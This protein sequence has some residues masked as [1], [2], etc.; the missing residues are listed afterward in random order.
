M[1]LLSLDLNKHAPDPPTAGELRFQVGLLAA[2][3]ATIASFV[4][5]FVFDAPLVPELLAQF[6][7]AIAPIWMVEIA[8]GMLGPFAKHLAFLGC[9]AIYL[10]GLI[11]AGVAYLRWV[12]ARHSPLARRSATAVFALCVWAFTGGVAL[13]LLGGGFFGSHLRQRLL[14]TT[15]ALLVVHI[16][17]GAALSLA[18]ERYIQRPASGVAPSRIIGRRR[19]VRAVGYSVLAL[20]VFDIG[21]SLLGSW[22]QS[23]SGRVKS[24]DGVFPNIDN[25]ALEVTPTTDFYQVSKNAFDP[26]VDVRGWKLEL[27]GLVDHPVSFSYDDIKALAPVEQYATLACIS[28]E[29]GGD[30]IGNALWR[31]A[32]LKDLLN[33]AGVKPGVVDIVLRA[34]DD[35]VDSIPLER[36]MA[37]GTLLV[38]EM[39]GEPLRPEHGFPLRLL[40]PGIYGMKNVK[41]ITRIEAI[42]FDLKGYWQK[43]GWD[44]RAAYKTMSRIDAPGGTVRGETTIAGIAFAGDRGISKVEVSTDG[45]AQWEQAE[46]KPALSPISWLLWQKRW[47][48]RQPGKHRVMVR[49]TDGRG[50]IQSSNSAPPAPSGSTGYHMIIISSE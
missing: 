10:I 36:A 43:R 31:G 27:A 42:D 29:V 30:L 9:T 6:I 15:S 40:V 14:L 17:Y 32:R 19:V 28:N 48:P 21:K 38:Y 16:V 8:V 37:E 25:L 23:G 11:A 45:G 46:I 5:R 20:G 49:A 4:A 50:E 26:Q 24:G 7:F 22:L 44:D 3:S 34:S 35:Y 33:E 2:V 1:D 41:W 13:P 39:N 18:T 12:P 47:S